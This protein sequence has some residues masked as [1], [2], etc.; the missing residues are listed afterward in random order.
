[1]S[2]DVCMY[3]LRS[4]KNKQLTSACGVAILGESAPDVLLL[5]LFAVV[6]VVIVAGGCCLLLL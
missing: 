1:V 6:V 4:G 3:L 5:L 2:E